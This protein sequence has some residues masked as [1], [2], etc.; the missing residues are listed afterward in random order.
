MTTLCSDALPTLNVTADKANSDVEIQTASS[1]TGTS[2]EDKGVLG[3]KITPHIL[4]VGETSTQASPDPVPCTISCEE[5]G[6]FDVTLNGDVAS[7]SSHAPVAQSTVEGRT[8]HPFAAPTRGSKASSK[9]P[10][11]RKSSG[12]GSSGT[13]FYRRI[14]KKR[15]ARKNSAF[16]QPKAAKML[17]YYAICGSKDTRKWVPVHTTADKDT[18]HRYKTLQRKEFGE[19]WPHEIPKIVTTGKRTLQTPMYFGAVQDNPHVASAQPTRQIYSPCEYTPQLVKSIDK[20]GTAA[21]RREG[22]HALAIFAQV[23]VPTD[24]GQTTTPDPGT[25]S[26]GLDAVA[27]KNGQ[28]NA[29]GDAVTASDVA[30]ESRDAASDNGVANVLGSP[31]REDGDVA[32]PDAGGTTCNAEPRSTMQDEHRSPLGMGAFSVVHHRSSTPTPHNACNSGKD[33]N[34]RVTDAACDLSRTVGMQ[35]PPPCSANDLPTFSKQKQLEQLKCSATW[36]L[37]DLL[38]AS[39]ADETSVLASVAKCSDFLQAFT[40]AWT[41]PTMPDA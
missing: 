26:A 22:Y 3:E 34:W 38:A 18:I 9:S 1:A 37:Q 23:T 6:K 12:S 33:F 30:I 10:S 36:L 27:A 21:F 24:D 8:K 4:N 20:F 17:G 7:S 32:M 11:R 2:D 31:S 25:A 14:G 15:D 35:V 29:A 16:E 13:G 19:A 40:T 5:G 39:V 41:T 28:E